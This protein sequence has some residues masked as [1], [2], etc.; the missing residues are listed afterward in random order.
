MNRL[1][2]H[3]IPCPLILGTIYSA[4]SQSFVSITIDDVPNTRKFKNDNFNSKLLDKLEALNIPIG[5]FINEGNIYK[6]DSTSKNLELLDK[7]VKS[8]L[9]SIGN[10]S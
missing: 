3:I 9:V 7:W 2:K 5:I 10:H 1:L 4:F 6:S 8:P